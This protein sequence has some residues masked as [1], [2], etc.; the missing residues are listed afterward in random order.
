M[1]TTTVIK[2]KQSRDLLAYVPHRL[3]YTPRRSLV[4][5]GMSRYPSGTR[6]GLVVRC[7]L[8]RV[9]M[10]DP[11]AATAGHMVENLFADTSVNAVVPVL[12]VDAPPPGAGLAGRDD[13]P[14]PQTA[15]VIRAAVV[16]AGF[17][18]VDE[19]WVAGDRW[20]SYACADADCCPPSGRPT[21]EIE[22]SAVGAELVLAGSSPAESVDELTALP[23]VDAE[24]AAAVRNAL[25]AAVVRRGD[26]T[27]GGGLVPWRRRQLDLWRHAF[28]AEPTSI[29][30][31][32]LARLI[33]ALAD[34][35]LRDGVLLDI[36]GFTAHAGVVVEPD[37]PPD[38]M[39]AM[40]RVVGADPSAP[41]RE[42]LCRAES[43][44]RVLAAT[45]TG[46]WRAAPLAVL[47]WIEWCRGR[48][49]TAG[50]YLDRACEAD[51]RHRLAAL[52]KGFVDGGLLPHWI[53]KAR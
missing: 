52:M 30:P 39:E 34:S 22:S 11:D 10:D 41:D 49:S 43:L 38:T 3:G 8:P 15:A 6:L 37:P 2:L 13:G 35:W 9:W 53:T 40:S 18:L 1:Q 17:V 23:A 32:E 7:D 31:D 48:S 26:E 19:L 47:G 42:R 45:A 25:D 24:T 36:F 44:V 5:I 51:P 4:L 27:G 50:I 28:D 16:D 12:Y 20:R 29:A 46:T 21:T 33:V 14:E